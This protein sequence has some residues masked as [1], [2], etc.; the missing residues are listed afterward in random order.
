MGLLGQLGRFYRQEHAVLVIVFS[1]AGRCDQA[2]G[3]TFGPLLERGACTP[4]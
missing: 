1:L 3:G 4:N 2:L